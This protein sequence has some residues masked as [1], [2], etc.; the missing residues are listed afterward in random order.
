MSKQHP[1]VLAYIFLLYEIF[2]RITLP[3]LVDFTFI[4]MS[5]EVAVD[6]ALRLKRELGSE[7]LWI[8]AYCNDVMAYIPSVRI[9]NEGGYE[10]DFSMMYYDLPGF[11]NPALEETIIRKVHE[12]TRQVGRKSNR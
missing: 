9:L 11:W 10:P 7:G 4:A 8:A 6:Y 5:G 12:L 3:P 1:T 2:Q